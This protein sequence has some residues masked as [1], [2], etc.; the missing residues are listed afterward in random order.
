M[1]L[2]D[3]DVLYRNPKPFLRSVQAYFPSVVSLGN[4]EL[5]ASVVLGEAFESV[6]CRIHL[7]RR[8]ASRQ[9]RHTC[10]VRTTSGKSLEFE[11]SL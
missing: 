3:T 10:W 1:K 5:L 11:R 4:G 2:L 7:L 6:D 9:Y 8:A